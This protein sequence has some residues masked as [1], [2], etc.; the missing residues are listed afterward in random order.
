MTNSSNEI[1][2]ALTE[3]AA[4]YREGCDGLEDREGYY[5]SGDVARDAA[6][7][8]QTAISEIRVLERVISLMRASL[9][10]TEV[11]T[12][13]AIKKA[14]GFLSMP[15]REMVLDRLRRELAR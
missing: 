7:D 4:W 12:V 10:T 15:N 2:D 8:L 13:D 1:A 14:I 3:R 11:V 9:P 6:S 5:A